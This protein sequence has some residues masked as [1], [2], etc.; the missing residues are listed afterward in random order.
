VLLWLY[1]YSRPGRS[2]LLRGVCSW[3][4]RSA[5]PAWI[6]LLCAAEA[7]TDA[8]RALLMSAF[9]PGYILT[10]IPGSFAIQK[11]GAKVIMSID[12]L[13]TASMCLLIPFVTRTGGPSVLAPMLTIIG[14]SHGP[15]IPALQVLK[16]DWLKPGPGRALILRLMSVPPMI[17]DLLSD[18]IYPAICVKAGWQAMPYIH[19]TATALFLGAWHLFVTDKPVLTDAPEPTK[20]SPAAVAATEQPPPPPPPLQP[21]EKKKTVEWRIFKLPCILSVMMAKFGTGVLSYSLEQWAPIYFVENLGCTPLQV[22]GYLFWKTPLYTA[23]DFVC[24]PSTSTYLLPLSRI[25]AL[26]LRL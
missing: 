25:F 5:L 16:K 20:A 9:F 21:E 15:L 26:P 24:P 2:R 8:Q 23:V 6:P 12:M 1:M 19:G 22:A 18:T 11:W 4:F 13:V 17:A 7:F 14:L 3:G 10:Q